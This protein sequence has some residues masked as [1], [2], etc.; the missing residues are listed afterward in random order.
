[1]A[2]GTIYLLSLLVAVFILGVL[3][4]RRRPSFS[5]RVL[6]WL[7]GITVP[8]E[9][10]AILVGRWYHNNHWLYNSWLPVE[11]CALLLIFYKGAG[12]PATKR[13]L[14]W[15]LL[16]LPLGIAVCYAA[17]FSFRV[18]NVY[19]MLFF[20]F[21]E[22]I[23]GFIFLTDSLLS[24]DDGSIFSH[25]L[26][27]TAVGMILYAC[28]F[29]LTHATWVFGIGFTIS[30]FWYGALVLL[31]NT[32]LYGFMIKTWLAVRKTKLAGVAKSI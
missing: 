6:A 3:T 5:Y 13:L 26:S 24:S 15:M 4:V 21:C 31:G 7:P 17:S 19:A 18:L 22:L 25:P 12:H 20:L 32:L 28:V 23:C 30:R 11:C 2:P 29:I 16:I 1:M 27:W 9:V 10:L 8:V 14:K